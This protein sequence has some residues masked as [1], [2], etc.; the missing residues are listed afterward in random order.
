MSLLVGRHERDGTAY[1]SRGCDSLIECASSL[2]RSP[3][4][5]SR[6]A[7]VEAPGTMAAPMDPPKVEPT[8]G[9]GLLPAVTPPLPPAVT[10][11]L[12]P[13]VTPPLPPAVTPPLRPAAT[14]RLPPAVTVPHLR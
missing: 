10:P 13:A 12:P 6:R 11:P 4:R 1:S 9:A 3:L 5:L 7:A 8:E 2:S 14:P